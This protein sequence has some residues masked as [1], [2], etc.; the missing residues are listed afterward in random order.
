MGGTTAAIV[1]RC[2]VRLRQNMTGKGER[3]RRQ[4]R[5]SIQTRIHT[6]LGRRRARLRGRAIGFELPGPRASRPR[7]LNLPEEGKESGHQ[8]VFMCMCFCVFVC[9]CVCVRRFFSVRP[10]QPLSLSL[11]SL[12]S[13]TTVSA[14]LPPFQRCIA[15]RALIKNREF[16]SAADAS[17]S[18]PLSSALPFSSSF[19]CDASR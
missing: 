3:G 5:F 1:R 6:H 10:S 18:I 9:L 19:A 17:S 15:V 13:P 16:F 11:S 14:I 2:A 12:C 7:P 8:F 4:R